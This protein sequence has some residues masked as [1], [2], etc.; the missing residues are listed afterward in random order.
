MSYLIEKILKEAL[1]QLDLDKLQQV[2]NEFRKNIEDEYEWAS[3]KDCFKST[4]QDVSSKLEKYLTNLGYNAVR[5]R[6]YYSN[7]SDNFEPNMD[8]WEFNDQQ[9][10]LKQWERNGNSSNGLKFPHWW[11]EV[12]N[13][14]II[15]VT[16]DQFHPGEEKNYRIGIYKKPNSSYKKG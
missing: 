13:R 10:F 6:G 4:C 8:D 1:K 15:D 14:Y 2:V 7:A 9:R 11:I 5:T 16:E 12:E 3:Y